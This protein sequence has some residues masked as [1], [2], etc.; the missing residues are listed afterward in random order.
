MAV[1][2]LNLPSYNIIDVYG[3]EHDYHIYAETKEIP[4]TCPHCSSCGLVGFGRREQLIKDLPTHGKR[5]GIYINT[6]RFQC[7]SCSK[8]FYEV[9]PAV[10]TNRQMTF[11]LVR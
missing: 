4:G 10:A 3:T 11:R 8:T 2:I 7:R 1:S 6:R 9:L 5:T